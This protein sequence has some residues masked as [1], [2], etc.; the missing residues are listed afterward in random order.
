MTIQTISLGCR[1]NALEADQMKQTA[2]QAGLKN[3]TLINSCAVTKEAVRQ[4]RQAIRKAKRQ[5]PTHKIIASGC[6]TQIDPRSFAN[7]PELDLVLGNAAKL[8]PPAMQKNGM[9]HTDIMTE[10]KATPPPPAPQKTRARA[11]VQIQTGC[12][13]R[14]TFCIIPYGRGNSRS[15]PKAQIVEQCKKLVDDGHKEIVLTGVDITS[16]GADIN[17]PHGLGTLIAHILSEVQDLPR[18]RLSSVDAVEL[19]EH[20]LDFMAHEPRLM[21]H[22]H[23]SLQSGDNMILKRMKRRHQREDAIALCQNLRQHRPDISFGAD[24]IAGFPTETETMFANSLRLIEECGLQWLHIFPF[25]PRENTP[26]A[27]MPQ[28]KAETIKER[29]KKLRQYGAQAKTHWL[30]SRIGKTEKILIEK[31]GFG[32]TES[33][34]PVHCDKTHQAGTILP[35]RI[36]AVQDD[37]LIGTTP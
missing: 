7:M 1:L 34:A 17:E 6:A 30:T 10:K 2:K 9:V 29:A 24:I 18:L 26:A 32:R 33:F 31:N 15:T 8:S 16:W 22:L 37:T 14:C 35:M 23:L 28:L 13:H 12:D 5:N 4:S 21:P 25:S 11:M 27:R 3:A 19:D 20:L 36:K